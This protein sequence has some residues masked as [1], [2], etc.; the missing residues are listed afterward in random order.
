MS[1]ILRGCTSSS[2]H[3]IL[4]TSGLNIN[5]APAEGSNITFVIDIT[6]RDFQNFKGQI[7]DTIKF[8]K[9]NHS[10][11]YEIKN[12]I[13]DLD[14][15][16]EYGYSTKVATGELAVEGLLIPLTLVKLCSELQIEILVSL[17]DG[18][19]FE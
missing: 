13:P 1:T 10:V 18:T 9:A 8:L 5:I 19:L 16:I 7:A 6:D 2:H 15:E 11:L 12:K 3:T 14:W 4:L 17:Y